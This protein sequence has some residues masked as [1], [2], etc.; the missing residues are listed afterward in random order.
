M[1]TLSRI[2]SI[3][4]TGQ[5]VPMISKRFSPLDTTAGKLV[6]P[7]LWR[8]TY[9]LFNV[10]CAQAQGIDCNQTKESCCLPMTKMNADNIIWYYGIRMNGSSVNFQVSRKCYKEKFG[11]VWDIIFYCFCPVFCYWFFIGRSVSASIIMEKPLQWFSCKLQQHFGYDTMDIWKQF[12]NTLG[13]HVNK[14][15]FLL[16]LRPNLCLLG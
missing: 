13:H 14:G 8:Y 1:N 2:K 16:I 3:T 4:G 10:D 9:L 11:N 7:W 15:F 6:H 5:L 12:E